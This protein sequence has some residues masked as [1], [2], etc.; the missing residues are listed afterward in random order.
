MKNVLMKTTLESLVLNDLIGT[1]NTYKGKTCSM[2]MKG[3]AINVVT[4]LLFYFIVKCIFNYM[5]TL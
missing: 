5:Y 3:K 4:F 2:S 1:S